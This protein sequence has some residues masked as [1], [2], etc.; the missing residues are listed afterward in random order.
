MIRRDPSGYAIGQPT[1]IEVRSHKK[2]A[3]GDCQIRES[4]HL[5]ESLRTRTDGFRRLVVKPRATDIGNLSKRWNVSRERLNGWWVE[6]GKLGYQRAERRNGLAG[7][8]LNYMKYQFKSRVGLVMLTPHERLAKLTQLWLGSFLIGTYDSLNGAVLA[9]K[10]G[11]T[12]C[13]ALDKL[14]VEERPAALTD[15]Q[16]LSAEHKVH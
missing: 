6:M 5:G 14:P 10:N 7:V 3:V 2:F 11:K 16:T 4:W 9:V 8:I 13:G 12:G 1:T 15:W